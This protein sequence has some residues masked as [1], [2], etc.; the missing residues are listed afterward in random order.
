M[1]TLLI[2]IIT[3]VCWLAPSY[4]QNSEKSAKEVWEAFKANP[5][6]MYTFLDGLADS[7]NPQ[8]YRRY[9]EN[10][11]TICLDRGVSF[12]VLLDEMKETVL[13]KSA[14]LAA[15]FGASLCLYRSV[16]HGISDMSKVMQIFPKSCSFDNMYVD[17]AAVYPDG[18]ILLACHYYK[19]DEFSKLEDKYHTTTDAPSFMGQ[20]NDFCKFQ[21]NQSKQ[22][23]K[24]YK[25]LLDCNQTMYLCLPD[26]TVQL[27]I[28]KNKGT[29]GPLYNISDAK[30]SDD[31]E[32]YV[33]YKYGR[34]GKEIGSQW[35]QFDSYE[36]ACASLQKTNSAAEAANGAAFDKFMAQQKVKLVKLYGINAYN[37]MNNARP[38]VG[39]PEG[40]LRDF[41]YM[42]PSMNGDR[43][44]DG[45]FHAYAFSHTDIS[46]YKVY[47]KT[48]PYYS[49]CYATGIST[50]Q[51]ILCSGGKVAAI[52][53]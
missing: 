13:P 31:L 50:P 49:L 44:N 33:G 2:A 16:A 17:D 26:G 47:K 29:Y 6:D 32:L 34:D 4:G 53:W 20:L 22:Q 7:D 18:K 27:G 5:S 37:A 35:L 10:F 52:K 43:N 41:C 28:F 9:I 42:S 48:L 12:D 25:A 15:T 39:M 30:E 21:P 14:D 40:I 8:E 24:Q 36:K 51:Y 46:G 45:V 19:L 11:V 38:Y 1:K 23:Y 3:S